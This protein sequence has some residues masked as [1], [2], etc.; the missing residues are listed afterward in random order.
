[1][2]T[3]AS[4]VRDVTSADGTRVRVTTAPDPRFGMQAPVATGMTV[5]TPGGLSLSSTATRTVTLTDPQNLLSLQTLTE[6]TTVNGRTH[7]T[8]FDIGTRTFTTT[9]PLGRRATRVVDAKGRTTRVQ[10]GTLTPSTSPTTPAA[11]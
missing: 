5:T 1:V 10:I 6:S 4:G 9:T 3:L 11:F 8:V 7:R 2:S